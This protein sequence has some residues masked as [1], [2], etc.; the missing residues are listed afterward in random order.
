MNFDVLKTFM[1]VIERGSITAASR[2]LGISQPAVS[3]QIASLEGDFGAKLLKRTAYGVEL[4]EAGKQVLL[5]SERV[6]DF[7]ND[8]KE[9]VA[10]SE[11]IV[12]G[13]ITIAASNI[14]GMFVMPK[15][16]NDFRRLYPQVNIELE[17]MNSR[18]A[19]DMLISGEVQIAAI[20]ESVSSDKLQSYKLLDDEIVLIAP[21]DFNVDS[22]SSVIDIIKN[23]VPLLRR[24]E[25]SSTRHIIDNLAKEAN[26]HKDSFN[27]IGL[28]N[29]VIPQVNAVS[30]GLGLAFVSK[31]S[32][33]KELSLNQIK[34]V[35]IE[36]LPIKRELNIIFRDKAHRNR[37]EDAFLTMYTEK[38]SRKI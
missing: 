22:F 10:K 24:K 2:Q 15:I 12:K 3:M 31:Q 6:H 9:A 26:Q 35:N 11:G 1:T 27:V 21:A 33:K 7:L 28:F 29:S 30:E 13:S 8:T 23:K 18:K 14:P 37:I 34:L 32:I 25:G 16:I 19:V 5:F 38:I 36:G 4:T 20:G 17:I